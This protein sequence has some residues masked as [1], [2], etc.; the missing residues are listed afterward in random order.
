MN[1]SR[2]IRLVV[3]VAGCLL[4]AAGA[5]SAESPVT[6]DCQTNSRLTHHYTIG[7]LEKALA[8]MP[9]NVKEYS[10]CYQVIDNQLLK[11][12]GG[13]GGLKGGS[14]GGSGGSFI[15]TPV[16]IVLI[17]VVLGG[18]ALAVRAARRVRPPGGG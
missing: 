9:A 4:V 1:R 18:V 11:Q 14:S 3:I 12:E 10:G 7:Q 8:T 16:L 15:S 6:F 5:A 2:L 17:L 13:T